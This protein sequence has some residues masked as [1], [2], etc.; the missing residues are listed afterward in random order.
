MV[1]IKGAIR[2]SYSSSVASI[3]DWDFGYRKSDQLLDLGDKVNHSY[4]LKLLIVR[5]LTCFCNAAIGILA[6][7]ISSPEV[8]FLSCP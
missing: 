3:D 2:N 1:K 7:N 4:R 8:S 5:L 6:R